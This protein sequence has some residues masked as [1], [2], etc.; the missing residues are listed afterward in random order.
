MSLVRQAA[1]AS[2][3]DENEAKAFLE[4][5]MRANKTRFGIS[6]ILFALLMQWAMQM[7]IKWLQDQF[8]TD[9]E[10]TYGVWNGEE[11]DDDEID[12][13]NTGEVD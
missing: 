13:G 7:L 5:G 9:H 1:E 3:G 12:L 4:K 10:K 11:A 8:Q 2:E 6:E